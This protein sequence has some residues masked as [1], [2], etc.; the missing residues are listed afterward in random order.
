MMA[1]TVTGGAWDYNK[2]SCACPAESIGYDKNNGCK[3]PQPNPYSPPD[4]GGSTDPGSGTDPGGDV[5]DP[6]NGGETQTSE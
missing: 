6:T 2:K 3:M 1:C 4:D 5:S